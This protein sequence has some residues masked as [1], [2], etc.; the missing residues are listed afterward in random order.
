MNDTDPAALAAA[1]AEFL[2]A[3]SAAPEP[4]QPARTLYTIPEAVEVLRIS[5]AHLYNLINRG[6]VK[7]TRL[8]RRVLIPAAEIERLQRGD[9][10]A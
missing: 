6:S 7:S 4:A 8:G 3:R 2:A 9:S 10:A 1:F 5:R